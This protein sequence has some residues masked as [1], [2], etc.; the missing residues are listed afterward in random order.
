[1]ADPSL[2][3]AADISIHAPREGGDTMLDPVAIA[4]PISIHAPRE[5][6]DK[7]NI[8]TKSSVINI[9]IHAPRE[10]GDGTGRWTS[11]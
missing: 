1:M 3:A 2:F 10:G 6:G 9:S 8:N 5:G 7:T 11:S 4:I